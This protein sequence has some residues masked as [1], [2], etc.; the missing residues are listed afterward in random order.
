MFNAVCALQSAR[1]WGP[2]LPLTVKSL[3]T[4]F[5]CSRFDNVRPWAECGTGTDTVSN[6]DG[7][8][9]IQ[10]YNEAKGLILQSK[11]FICNLMCIKGQPKLG[12]EPLIKYKT[13]M[14]SI[15]LKSSFM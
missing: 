1:R 14:L 12:P 3:S 2:T 6:R 9:S 8:K 10:T 15:N 5:A 4:H 7:D 11:D 13:Q